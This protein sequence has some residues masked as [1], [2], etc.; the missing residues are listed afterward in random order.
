MSLQEISERRPSASVLMVGNKSDLGHLRE[1]E[2][3]EARTLTLTH[4]ARFSELST[5][6]SCTSVSEVIDNFL[7]EVKA[8]RSDNQNGSSPRLRKISVTRMLSSLIGRNSP[9]PAP[10]THLIILDKEERNKLQ[11]PLALL[12]SPCLRPGHSL[13]CSPQTAV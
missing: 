6:E 8:Q 1:V 2:E 11:T 5:A 4:S 13:S 7:K 3:I 9:P 10:S 12:C